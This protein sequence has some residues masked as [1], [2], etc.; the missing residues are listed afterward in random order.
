MF[1]G[2]LLPV[3]F[4]EK[5]D[6]HMIFEAL[7]DA[8]AA[9]IT[10]AV[11]TNAWE[12]VR[13]RVSRLLSRGDPAQE[14]TESAYLDTL[15]VFPAMSAT[16]DTDISPSIDRAK[17]VFRDRVAKL[18]AEEPELAGEAATTLVEIRKLV[19]AAHYT[20]F[21][22]SDPH[23]PVF[24]AGGDF[25]Y[26]GSHN[27]FPDAATLAVMHAAQAAR[28][29]EKMPPHEAILRLWTMHRQPD[30]R[31]MQP[32]PAPQRLALVEPERAAGLLANMTDTLAAELLAGMAPPHPADL[33]ARLE[34]ERAAVI[35]AEMND[36]SAVT[37]LA[38]LEPVRAA[39]VL[40]Y[41]DK[42]R[43]ATLLMLMVPPRPAELFSRLGPER[44]TAILTEMKEESAVAR[45]AE[46]ERT[47]AAS[48]L[49]KMDR[50]SAAK[51][52]GRMASP[53]SIQILARME[54]VDAADTLAKMETLWV[55]ARLAEM[56]PA[57]ALEILAAL[58]PP[59]PETLLS[60]MDRPLAVALL[61]ES[62][63]VLGRLA[64]NKSLLDGAQTQ[65]ERIR[66]D[67]EAAAHQLLTQAAEA[68]ATAEREAQKMLG[69]T[70][71]ETDPLARAIL[72]ELKRYRTRT[73][74]DLAA[75]TEAT[76]EVTL[77]TINRLIDANK[78]GIAS[79]TRSGTTSYRLRVTRSA[80]DL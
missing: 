63:S 64:E 24:M 1:V 62:V 31:A 43:A 69:R 36:D 49:S 12:A 56:A 51:L 7:V 59:G 20:H 61:R 16:A 46:M 11:A 32:E 38:E 52:F 55:C 78:I 57:R 22:V 76:Q 37:R 23:G 3:R 39:S 67:A 79:R 70:P 17:G 15:F 21:D 35:L 8:L 77:A 9:A 48:L 71:R 66:A 72:A 42:G 28:E 45:L 50:I 33:F 30:L 6:K 19:V 13:D 26:G 68:R 10:S 5:R 4:G 74:A 34:P 25:F 41:M 2:I 29:L 75:V 18:L 65:A 80:V 54:P 58:R 47:R 53:L 60:H 14:K 44:A 40:F 73:L 27:E